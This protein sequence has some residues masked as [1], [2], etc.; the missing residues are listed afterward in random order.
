MRIN[1][2]QASDIDVSISI[3]LSICLAYL[4]CYD[5][6]HVGVRHDWT[7]WTACNSGCGPGVQIRQRLCDPVTMTCFE[8]GRLVYENKTC[9][10]PC[11]FGAISSVDI[12]EWIKNDPELARELD[13]ETCILIN[14]LIY[15]RQ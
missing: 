15:S 10:N 8:A 2:V 12:G 7:E 9:E 4:S 6:A 14:S 5:V 3:Y 13:C 1:Y 11:Q